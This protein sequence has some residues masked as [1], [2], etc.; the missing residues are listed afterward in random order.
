MNTRLS[1]LGAWST[2]LVLPALFVVRPQ[3]EAPTPSMASGFVW[4]DFDGDGL[5]DAFVLL[6]TGQSGLLRNEGDGRLRD[7]TT[8]AGLSSIRFASFA[9]WHD[10]NADGR[11]DLFVATR[12]TTH[13]F[14][15]VDGMTFEDVAPT[16]G[17]AQQ[18]GVRSAHWVDYDAD[19]RLDL[20]LVTRSGGQLLRGSAS[21][22]FEPTPVSFASSRSPDERSP[23]PGGFSASGVSN[24]APQG[25]TADA[26]SGQGAA[27]CVT[28]LRDAGSGLSC[29]E[30]SSTPVLGRLYP[31]SKH[32]FVAVS[33]DVG[34]S[35]LQPETR[36]HVV[37][38]SESPPLPQ[39]DGQDAFRCDAGYGMR[40]GTGAFVNGGDG[41]RDGGKGLVVQGGVG[42]S[43]LG[44]RGGVGAQI[45]G[46]GVTAFDYY[47]YGGDG[48]QISGG[49]VIGDYSTG[50]TGVRALGGQGPGYYGYGGEG[51][52]LTGGAGCNGGT[53]A[54][55]RGGEG[56]RAGMGLSAYGANGVTDAPLGFGGSGG[57]GA[58]IRGGVGRAGGPPSY[59]GGSGGQGV[60]IR[61]G[62]T[63]GY[64]GRG[65]DGARIF[66]GSG[67]NAAGSTGGVGLRVEGGAGVPDGAFGMVVVGGDGDELGGPGLFVKGGSGD[68]FGGDGLWA[69]GTIGTSG[70]APAIRA[71]GNVNVTGNLCATGTIGACSDERFKTNVEPL[72]DALATVLALRGVSYDWKTD[73]FPEREFAD[74]RQLGLLAQEVLDVVPEIVSIDS[75]GYYAVDY[76]KLTPVLVEA[77][78]ELTQR[79]QDRERE[80]EELHRRLEALEGRF[81]TGKGPGTAR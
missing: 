9:T 40:G 44:S 3:G 29:L 6:E 19:G 31:I 66:G 59:V 61:G 43:F 58:V 80:L 14:E 34:L 26:A 25:V 13:L 69:E 75:D 54:I 23:T 67:F 36:L 41:K 46:G 8:E 20:H 22:R 28:S 1:V 73:E 50:G 37:A 60:E 77:V 11:L 55:L 79:D 21:G 52:V 45:L 27:S 74:E 65:G 70:R 4:G 51:A 76:G 39:L 38:R 53:G 12:E 71:T 15:N 10:V 47:T 7:V 48:A 32:L 72:C 30:A 17:L 24:V 42:R 57:T 81:A 63:Q 56:L 18:R 49:N 35:T 5:D 62:A 68:A 33:G 64:L 2:L 78:R 16:L